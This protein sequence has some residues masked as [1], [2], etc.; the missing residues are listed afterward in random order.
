MGLFVV[1][2]HIYIIA[3]HETKFS[4]NLILILMNF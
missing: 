3:K 1:Q 4:Q 2:L